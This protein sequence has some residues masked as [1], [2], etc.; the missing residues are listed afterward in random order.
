M[1][2]F[3]SKLVIRSAGTDFCKTFLWDKGHHYHS[4]FRGE[5]VDFDANGRNLGVN[6]KNTPQQPH[7]RGSEIL[8][9][10]G[11]FVDAGFQMPFRRPSSELGPT[12][13]F[14]E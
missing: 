13:I 3:C 12:G 7:P 8:Q 14:A 9:A 5:I 10:L 1:P 4:I 11:D 6:G 2:F